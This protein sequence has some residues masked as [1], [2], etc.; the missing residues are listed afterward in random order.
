MQE[1]SQGSTEGA[2]LLTRFEIPKGCV[3]MQPM[4]EIVADYNDQC[5]EC[6]VWHESMLSLYW[7]DL[8]SKWRLAAKISAICT[9]I[10][11]DCLSPRRPCQLGYD[12]VSGNFGGALYRCVRM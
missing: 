4:C 11:P 5:G 10:L 9:L 2:A 7:S 12:H 3:R 8:L 1:C 6:P